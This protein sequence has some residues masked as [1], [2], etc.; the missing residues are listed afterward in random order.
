MDDKADAVTGAAPLK[1]CHIIT[2]LELGGA[3]Q[4]TLYTVSHLDRNSF[5]V[6]LVCGRGGMLDAQAGQACPGTVFAR[7]LLRPVNPPHDT[8]AIFE[9]RA[10]LRKIKPDI[11]HTHSSKAGI[12]GRLAARAAGVPHIAHTF[13]GFGFN[14]EQP[15]PVRTAYI[16]AEKLCAA[17]CDRLIFVSRA[18]MEE[19]R[20]LG[21]GKPEKYRLIRSGVKLS[22]Y[23]LEKPDR[24]GVRREM[25]FEENCPLAL[26]VGN[27]KPQKNPLDFVR[28]AAEISR[29]VPQARFIFTGDGPMRAE[30]EQ[31]AR[32]LGLA[33]KLAFPGWRDDT[34]RLMAAADIYMLASLWEGLPRSVVEALASGLPCAAYATDG[35]ADILRDGENGFILPRKDIAGLA[36]KAADM[37]ADAG[38]RALLAK[39]AA[40]TDLREFDIDYMVAQQ[41]QLYKEMACISA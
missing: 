37:L 7:H 26:C 28:I 13:H 34:R 38:L 18:N 1:V 14:S 15:V 39:N 29:K 5:A 6:S 16:T 2:K 32:E 22:D 9:L 33:G 10:I 35:V 11:V 41:E 17:F 20:A 19:A 24:A 3:Q 30:A 23:R 8:A 12:L 40:G 4:N 31:L 25:G 27:L 21:L 36:G